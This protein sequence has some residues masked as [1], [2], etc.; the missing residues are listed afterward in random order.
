MMPIQCLNN[1]PTL[2][3]S[4][5]RSQVLNTHPTH[6][7]TTAFMN[8]RGTA[9]ALLALV[10][11]FLASAPCQSAFAPLPPSLRR[12]RFCVSRPA[13]ASRGDVRS[14]I[15][16]MTR[17]LYENRAATRGV[18]IRKKQLFSGVPNASIREH[19]WLNQRFLNLSTREE[20]IQAELGRLLVVALQQQIKND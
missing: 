3:K 2:K 1:L 20:E 4:G 11:L 8:T 17:L 12:H 19:S 15:E 6:P 13:M 18:L 7:N 5:L 9:Y 10:L 16:H 14:D